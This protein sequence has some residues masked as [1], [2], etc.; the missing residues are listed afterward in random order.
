MNI[1]F[2]YNKVVGADGSITLYNKLYGE[3]YHAVS[4]GAYTETLHKHI[5]PS[6]HFCPFLLS[7]DKILILDICFGLGYN[8]L[9]TLMEY[10][11]RGFKG[12]IEIYAP[13]KDT[14]LLE[15]LLTFK[16]PDILQPYKHIISALVNTGYY[17]N[18]QVSVSLYKGDANAYIYEL[19]EQYKYTFFVIYQDPFSFKKN[20]A[21]WSVEYFKLLYSLL[22]PQGIITT[23]SQ[24]SQIIQRACS[25]GFYA[26]ACSN[27]HGRGFS[28]FS[29]NKLKN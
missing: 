21:L 22:H 14:L 2:L 27:K 23:Y 18:Q 9:C 15:Y 17:S 8:T 25:V 20:E 11:K 1:E 13:E 28:V 6:L 29:K 7:L 19:L 5:Y 10:E 16:Y 24:S 3:S 12:I 4:E 26:L